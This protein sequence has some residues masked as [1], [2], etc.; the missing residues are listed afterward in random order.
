[1]VIL[2][3]FGVAPA[4]LFHPDVAVAPPAVP[5]PCPN[6]PVSFAIETSAKSPLNT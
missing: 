6:N 1:M 2:D 3:V 5:L 4:I